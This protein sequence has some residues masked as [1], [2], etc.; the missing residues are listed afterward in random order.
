ML[1]YS[2]GMKILQV[3]G[4]GLLN[5]KVLLVSYQQAEIRYFTRIL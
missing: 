2:D 1:A 4:Q 5:L 3:H